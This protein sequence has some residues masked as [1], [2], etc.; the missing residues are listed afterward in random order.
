MNKR[1]QKFNTS[2]EYILSK[3]AIL[4]VSNLC[5]N[6]LISIIHEPCYPDTRKDVCIIRKTIID[7][8]GSYDVIYLLWKKNEN[9]SIKK[10][11]STSTYDP[12]E[13]QYL[14][15]GYVLELKNSIVIKL[16]TSND[17]KKGFAIHPGTIYEFKKETLGLK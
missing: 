1:F 8:Q 9:I 6:D 17:P 15:I 12:P 13:E 3:D 16:Y 11:W 14:F 7:M 4:A 2:F 5:E 10:I